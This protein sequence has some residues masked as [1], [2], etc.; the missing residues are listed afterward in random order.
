[1]NKVIESY[2]IMQINDDIEEHLAE[3]NADTNV[4]KG[5]LFLEWCLANVFQLREDE[6]ENA[7]AIGGK[8]DNGIDAVFESNNELF[9]IQSKYGQSQNVDAIHRFI[10]DSLRLLENSPDSNRDA[11]IDATF[12]IRRAFKEEKKINCYYVTNNRLSD[13]EKSQVRKALDGRTALNTSFYILDLDKIIE[14][15]QLNRGELPA[16]FKQK[17]FTIKH[18]R[19]F[20]VDG[21]NGQTYVT[22]VSLKA[23]ADFIA[24]D[25]DSD[26]IFYSN[27]RNYLNSTSINSGIRKTIE[28][29]PQ[30][31]W[32]Y[33]NGITVVCEEIFDKNSVLVVKAPQI[34]NGCQTA[35]NIY[36]AYK[37]VSYQTAQDILEDGQILV[38]FI[39]IKKSDA[40]E[41][42]EFRDN[43]TRY[44]NS[45]NAVKGLDFYSLDHFQRELK[46][47]FEKQGYYYEIQRGSY[48]AEKNRRKKG[49]QFKGH[50]QYN[51]LI[52][53][54][55]TA[56]KFVLPAKEVIQAFTAGIKMMPNIAYGRAN[57]LT[58][59]GKRWEEIMNE[60]T[61]NY[62]VEAFLF[63]YL[64]WMYVK[65]T[66]KF[67]R[68]SEV[69]SY[70][71][72]AAF[73]FVA[74]HFLLLLKL[75]NKINKTEKEYIGTDDLELL[76]R[77]FS[78]QHINEF[79]LK[80]T[81]NTLKSFF[82][83]SQIK[84]AVGDDIRGFIQS[85]ISNRSKYW[86]ILSNRLDYEIEDS[87]L[88][89]PEW[90]DIKA[91][92]LNN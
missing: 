73:L 77:I 25:K 63:P 92:Y 2:L 22:A 7:T 15:I 21:K 88:E 54:F 26:L 16:K 28:N 70:R 74:T 10:N 40:T 65:N 51:Y 80:V 14:K 66:L 3:N 56:K 17:D 19:A 60:E 18:T 83:D 50:N 84:E 49:E 39:K 67:N 35:K 41:K 47:Q 1:M 62:K 46:R 44:T 81:N 24:Q 61:K 8:S 13:W 11:V 52:K 86:D 34:V 37:K 79:L 76:K 85:Q 5:N 12:E 53:D 27:I 78:N 72:H 48:T 90:E 87:V 75:S 68:T 20:T 9:I 29:N 71:K 33:N 69:D 42:K 55:N 31:F 89:E 45:Q 4:K 23:F 64:T 58:P 6:I 91:I 38:R 43:I 36:A 59:M 30:D 82:R 32:Y 57:E